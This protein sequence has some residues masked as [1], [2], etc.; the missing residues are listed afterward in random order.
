VVFDF[1]VINYWFVREPVY[2]RIFKRPI[3][4]PLW[5]KDSPHI[6]PKPWL[7]LARLL[8]GVRS[9]LAVHALTQEINIMKPMKKCIPGAF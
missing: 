2:K 6:L 3:S 4:W 8:P 5:E 1:F 9:R 7:F